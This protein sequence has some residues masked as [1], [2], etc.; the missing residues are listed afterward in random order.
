MDRCWESDASKILSTYDRYP[1][2]TNFLQTDVENVYSIKALSRSN[3]QTKF[4][5]AGPNT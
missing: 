5:T 2:N 4:Q 3:A 1:K